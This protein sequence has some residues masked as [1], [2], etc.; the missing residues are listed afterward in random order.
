MAF[1]KLYKLYINNNLLKLYY[2][3]YKNNHLTH[4]ESTSKNLN[5]HPDPP[6]IT[7]LD[8]LDQ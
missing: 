5:H 8:L 6:H 7:H 1:S 4:S 3:I 2:S